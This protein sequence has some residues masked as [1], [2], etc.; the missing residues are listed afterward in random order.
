MC[1]SPCRLMNIWIY[2]HKACTKLLQL[3]VIGWTMTLLSQ[4]AGE[5]CFFFLSFFVEAILLF[6]CFYFWLAYV[7]WWHA[8]ELEQAVFSLSLA[9]RKS[10]DGLFKNVPSHVPVAGAGSRVSNSEPDPSPGL[11]DFM[12]LWLAANYWEGVRTGGEG[13]HWGFKYWVGLLT[14]SPGLFLGLAVYYWTKL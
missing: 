12:I 13:S 3:T 4:M 11:E 7:L 5:G 6:Q 10:G 2:L 9:L 1:I 8:D 14:S